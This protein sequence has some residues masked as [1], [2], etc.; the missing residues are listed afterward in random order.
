[1]LTARVASRRQPRSK[2]GRPTNVVAGAAAASAMR[3]RQAPGHCS[4]RRDNRIEHGDGCAGGKGSIL[5]D[6]PRLDRP[7]AAL[8][9]A[10]VGAAAP[11]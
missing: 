7:C 1:M 4:S 6:F 8:D 3:C 2:K 10:T 9:T 11:S 5:N